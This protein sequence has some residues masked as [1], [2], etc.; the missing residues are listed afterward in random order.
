V[1]AGIRGYRAAARVTGF[2]R[3]CLFRVSCSRHV[4]AVAR[5]HGAVAA[6]RAMRLRF[7]NCRP[8]YAFDFDESDWAITCIAGLR[9]DSADA[10]VH[11]HR[12]AEL[13]RS[14]LGR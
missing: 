7:A 1:V 4:E 14:L 8:G 5:A 9:V 10:S 6:V 3:N 11:V 2:R 12:E 13:L